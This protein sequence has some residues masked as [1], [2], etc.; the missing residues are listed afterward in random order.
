[1]KIGKGEIHLGIGVFVRIVKENKSLFIQFQ[2]FDMGC[3]EDITSRNT[4]EE[5]DKKNTG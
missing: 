2:S 1:M 5:N 4:F 3:L